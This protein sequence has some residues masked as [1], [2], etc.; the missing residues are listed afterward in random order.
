MNLNRRNKQ[1]QQ[2]QSD[3]HENPSRNLMKMVSTIQGLKKCFSQEIETLK[4]NQDEI[5]MKLK[6]PITQ[7][8]KSRESLRST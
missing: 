3:A 7:V 2:Q 5:K 6:N 4:R 1:Q 8:E